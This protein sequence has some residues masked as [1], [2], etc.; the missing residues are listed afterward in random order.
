[1][2]AS[3]PRAGEQPSKTTEASVAGSCYQRVESVSCRKSQAI[4]LRGHVE[5]SGSSAHRFMRESGDD[6]R[7][8]FFH[9]LP[10]ASAAMIASATMSGFTSNGSLCI[11]S[12]SAVARTAIFCSTSGGKSVRP[13]SARVIGSPTSVAN[14]STRFSTERGCPS[15][16][17]WVSNPNATFSPCRYA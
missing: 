1:M 9:A 17:S 11:V 4:K 14:L 12:F 13:M 10:V 7:S 15:S 6:E 5:R 8:S 3:N 2:P 16:T